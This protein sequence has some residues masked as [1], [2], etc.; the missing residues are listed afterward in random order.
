MLRVFK[1]RVIEQSS[2]AASL[3]RI[4]RTQKYLD[5]SGDGFWVPTELLLTALAEVHQE[6]EKESVKN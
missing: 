3:T 6:F 1:R 5:S 4:A 2:S